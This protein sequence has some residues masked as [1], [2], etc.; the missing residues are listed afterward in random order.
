MLSHPS[1]LPRRPSCLDKVS[2][3]P[4]TYTPSDAVP[5]YSVS[6]RPTERIL[7]ATA[8]S[9]RRT[10]TGVF[11]RSNSLIT[12][13]LREQEEDASMPSYGRQGV[14]SGDIGLSC[15]QGVQAVYIKVRVSSNSFFFL[16]EPTIFCICILFSAGGQITFGKSGWSNGGPDVLL[17][18][19]RRLEEIT[20]RRLQ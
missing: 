18:F 9:R 14:I 10:P 3:E 16:P 17:R 15:T 12:L 6:P 2:L 13:A 5:A 7:A 19:V 11:V 20:G 1:L 4:P 8:R